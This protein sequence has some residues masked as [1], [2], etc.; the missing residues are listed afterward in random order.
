[1]DAKSNIIMPEELRE[2]MSYLQR[3]PEL[4]AAQVVKRATKMAKDMWSQV[5]QQQQSQTKAPPKRGGKPQDAD[6]LRARMD[7]AANA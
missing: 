5:H 6:S 2:F 3:M 1:M 7:R 4:N